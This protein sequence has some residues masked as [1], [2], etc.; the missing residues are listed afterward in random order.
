M[1]WLTCYT[2]RG[3][4]IGST[5]TVPVLH[6]AFLIAFLAIFV[7]WTGNQLWS[8]IAFL[9]HQSRS[10]SATCDVLHHQQQ[11][12]LRNTAGNIEAILDFLKL[13]RRWKSKIQGPL[14]RNVVFI[15][16]AL[17]HWLLFSAAGIF[18]SKFTVTG[19]EALIR[20]GDCGWIA[21]RIGVDIPANQSLKDAMNALYVAG[22][23][24]ARESLEYS[25]ACYET[26]SNSASSA[27]E[28][29]VQGKIES[30]INR[31]AACPFKGDACNE[32]YAM[33]MDSG[34]M[35]S[36]KH[37]GINTPKSDRISMRRVTTCSVVPVE[38]RF[39]LPWTTIPDSE[40]SPWPP[41]FQNDFYRQYN[42]GPAESDLLYFYGQGVA[43]QSF[44]VSNSSVW[45]QINPYELL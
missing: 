41:A 10:T 39:S 2:E 16:I 17:L 42:I 8:V 44:I 22:R 6:G 15:L 32:D 36:S 3:I 11:V 5:L 34:H 37:L 27:C 19:D 13:S 31:T 20:G 40:L 23:K 29:F 38:Q 25:T 45:N 7:R 30:R 4:F 28:T 35:D 26:N 9:A 21:G 43:N 12:L 14:R 24:T 18:S 1:V 33:E